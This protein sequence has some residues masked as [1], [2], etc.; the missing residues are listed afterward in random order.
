STL[1]SRKI[2][3]SRQEKEE[4]S[5]KKRDLVTRTSARDERSIHQRA[6]PGAISS[7][8][9]AE[10]SDR[11]PNRAAE[12]AKVDGEL[13]LGSERRRGD[14]GEGGAGE[15]RDRRHGKGGLVDD[16]SNKEGFLS[17]RGEEEKCVGL[18]R[19]KPRRRRREA[20]RTVN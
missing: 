10:G 17:R 13:R 15:L 11:D 4:E 3:D 18:L 14:R 9:E 19:W 7:N 1:V 12:S 5:N 16:E 2:G 6:S 20:G 8:R